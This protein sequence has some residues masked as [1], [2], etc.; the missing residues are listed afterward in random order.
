MDEFTTVNMSESTMQ[1]GLVVK[2][3]SCNTAMVDMG[4][5]PFRTGGTSGA[6]HI[7]LGNWAELGEGVLHLD[8]FVCQNCGRVQLFA[9]SRTR[10]SL[11][12]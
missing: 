6:A 8:A 9:D 7:F 2:C 5:I 1:D 3:Q 4:D 12:G 10:D 11:N